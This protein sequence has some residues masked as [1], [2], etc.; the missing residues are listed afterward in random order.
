M[1]ASLLSLR[2]LLAATVIASS[3]SLSPSAAAQATEATLAPAET[4]APQTASRLTQVSVRALTGANGQAA[5]FGFLLANPTGA[6]SGGKMN[7]IVRGVGPTLSQFG[8]ANALSAPVLTCTDDGAQVPVYDG[9]NSGDPAAAAGLELAFDHVGAFALPPESGDV[10]YMSGFNIG[11]PY[12]VQLASAS[13]ATGVVL[14]EIYDLDDPSAAAS[15]VN[16]SGLA[17]VGTG[18]DVLTAGFAITGGTSMTLLVRGVG[19]GSR[20]VRRVGIAPAPAAQRL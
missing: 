2:S 16:F 5:V 6:S 7:L 14:G 18:A 1:T 3:A 17:Q 9:W 20:P 15:L 4:G 12:T 8:V 13:G 10:A 11:D 19:P